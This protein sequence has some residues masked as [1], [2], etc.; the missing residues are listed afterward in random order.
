MNGLSREESV[1]YVGS[2]LVAAGL[3]GSVPFDAAAL[4][5]LA[6]AGKGVPRVLNVL[7]HKALLAAL[8]AQDE[9]ARITFEI[10]KLDAA[11]VGAYTTRK[12]LLFA[13]KGVKT[14][15][16]TL[17]EKWRGWGEPLGVCRT[18]NL[19]LV[20]GSWRCKEFAGI[21]PSDPGPT[22][23]THHVFRYAHLR[24]ADNVTLVS[25]S[26]VERAKLMGCRADDPRLQKLAKL[27]PTLARTVTGISFCAQWY[28]AVL[29]AA[30]VWLE[31][32]TSDAQECNPQD[33]E[34][35][36]R[37]GSAAFWRAEAQRRALHA[38]PVSGWAPARHRL[39]VDVQEGNCDPAEY[40]R[41][42]HRLDQKYL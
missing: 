32:R 19:R 3:S 2:R 13:P 30:A 37:R 14:M 20:R 34:S 26:A 9:A 8:N 40:A 36:Q 38:P 23:T 15:L 17:V 22:V 31:G 10:T 25:L 16:P 7:S 12:R 39:C 11:D 35:M 6:E 24:S 29:T 5:R 21:W 33:A 18:S 4:H 41:R 1:D 28:L 27:P 42:R